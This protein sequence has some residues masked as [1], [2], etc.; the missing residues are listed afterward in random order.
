MIDDDVTFLSE[1]TSFFEGSG[2]SVMTASTGE[3]GVRLVEK[4]LGR[5]EMVFVDLRMPDMDGI[6]VA[7]RVRTINS[8]IPIAVMSAYADQPEWRMRVHKLRPDMRI[9]KPLPPTFGVRYKKFI[10]EINEIKRSME[11]P[12]EGL[13]PIRT[14]LSKSWLK[15]PFCITLAQFHQLSDDE[16]D[17]LYQRADEENMP[18][19]RDVFCKDRSIDWVLIAHRPGQVVASGK[20]SDAPLSDDLDQFSESEGCLVYAYSRPVVVEEY[21]TGWSRKDDDTIYPTITFEFYDLSGEPKRIKG[22]FDTGCPFSSISY[23]ILVKNNIITRKRRIRWNSNVNDEGKK[24]RL[25]GKSYKYY[26]IKRPC[27][28]VGRN[29]GRKGIDFTFRAVVNWGDSPMLMNY[30]DRDAFIG[31]DILTKNSVRIVLD[32]EASE[33]DLM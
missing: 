10:D 16:V 24:E 19:V 28:V 18:Y 9:E 33:T 22:D 12:H 1:A 30:D 5:C 17:S 26:L 11:S 20:M 7:E 8:D 3:D 15:D 27:S 23:E 14:D 31:R 25:W 13:I 21:G 6:E 29:G 32:G 2:M 4:N